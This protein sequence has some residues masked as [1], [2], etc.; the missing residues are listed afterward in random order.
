MEGKVNAALKTLSKD[1]ENGVLQL[2]EKVLKNLNLK[3]PAP[4]EVKKYNEPMNKIPNYYFDEIDE[5]MTGKAA[6]LTKGSGSLS[7]VD[8][9]HFR[10]MLLSKKFKIEGKNLREQIALL[11]RNL[12][13][14]FVDPFS[15]EAL[16]TC[17]LIPLNKNLGVRPIGKDEVLRRVMDKAIN[18]ILRED[19]KEAAGSLQTAT[20]LKAFAEVAIHAMRTIFEDPITE[21]VTLVDASNAFNTVNRRIALHNIQMSCSSF[22]RILI[23]TY[24]IPSRM[25]VL[26]GAELQFTEGTTQVYNLAMPF[27]AIS[28]VQILQILRFSVSDVKQVW[29]ADDA[30]VVGSLKSLKNWW[31]NMVNERDRFGYYVNDKKSGLIVKN[32]T[33]LETAN[34]LFTNTKISIATEGKRHLGS[35]IGS[36]KFRVKYVIEKV[37]EWIDELRTLSTYAKSQP[38]AVYAAF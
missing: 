16:T 14:K 21:G 5:M 35:A 18:W 3:H 10:H 31:T 6:S 2:D 36:N 38:K 26:G 32:Q 24:H 37:D 27:Y 11:S 1:Y 25:I 28:T 7:H 30:T 29:L 13:S 9:D 4:A 19:I 34:N 8:A 33:Q 22:S 20:G 23:N 17:R 15:I 12:A